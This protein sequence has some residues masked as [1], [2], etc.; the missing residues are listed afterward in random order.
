MKVTS[1]KTKTRGC[2]GGISGIGVIRGIGSRD[3]YPTGW[4]WHKASGGTITDKAV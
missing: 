1:R 3:R 4:R 2:S